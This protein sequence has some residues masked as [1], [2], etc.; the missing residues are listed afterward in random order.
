MTL[1][2]TQQQQPFV[3]GGSLR[4]APDDLSS[5]RRSA[6]SCHLSFFGGNLKSAACVS[7]AVKVKHW[8]LCPEGPSHFHF[9]L[10]IIAEVQN[11]VKHAHSSGSLINQAEQTNGADVPRH[12]RRLWAFC[13]TCEQPEDEERASLAGGDTS[14]SQACSEWEQT[15]GQRPPS[16][17]DQAAHRPFF[18]LLISGQITNS[19][20]FLLCFSSSAFFNG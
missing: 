2:K 5:L 7:Q 19:S 18:G 3:C 16:H 15:Q 13:F 11:G 14:E 8:R 9:S 6:I 10:L 12:R 4:S 17:A 20:A 1:T